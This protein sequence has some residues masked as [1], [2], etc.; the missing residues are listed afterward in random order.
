MPQQ[1]PYI[2]MLGCFDT[3]G[4]VFSFLRDCLIEQ[5]QRVVSINTGI[6]NT[7]ELFPVD[8][9]ADLI[10]MEGGHRL[11]YLREKRDRGFA[12]DIMGK[13]IAK[14][15]S[16]LIAQGGVKG[17]ISM[18]G[19]GGTYIALSA[20]RGIP[21]GI[22]KL[23]LSTLA[24]KDLS[25]QVGN[26]DIVLMSSVVDVAGLNSISKGLI[27]QAAAAICAMSDVPKVYEERHSG[28]IALSMFG[29]TTA[30]VDRC[31]DLLKKQNFEVLAFHANGT[32]GRTME[33]LIREGCFD[34]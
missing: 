23:C 27:R 31:T 8:I 11:D 2:I 1:I 22:P 10:T 26:K 30:C 7:T 14:V 29:N 28:S 33:A 12:V 18:G 19:G 17:A 5:G 32:G 15:I 20:M 4:E 6:L 25:Q 24:A 34:R 9:E 3:K 21:I 13:G 16:F